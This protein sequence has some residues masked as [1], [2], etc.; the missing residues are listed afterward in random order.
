MPEALDRER[1]PASLTLAKHRILSNYRVLSIQSAKLKIE[2]LR[3]CLSVGRWGSLCV[4]S[5]LPYIQAE[6]KV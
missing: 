2:P 3:K 6:E 1:C 4:R 5:D